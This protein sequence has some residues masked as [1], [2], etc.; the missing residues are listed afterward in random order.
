MTNS[1][2]INQLTV[3]NFG[4]IKDVSVKLTPLHAFI[5]PND[6]GK[7]TLLRAARTGMQL[8]TGKFEGGFPEL[9]Q[10]KE[11]KPFHPGNHQN[12]EI[13]I[14]PNDRLKYSV[15]L[16]AMNIDEKLFDHET[17]T[18]ANDRQIWDK[19]GLTRI[20]FDLLS[21]TDKM[22]KNVLLPSDIP[23]GNSRL[24]DINFEKAIKQIPRMVRLDPDS[25]RQPGGLIPS[26]QPIDF[27]ENGIGLAGVLD[28]L[29]KRKIDG[30]ISLREKV[31]E[32]FPTVAS[33]GLKNITENEMSIEF[34]LKNGA[35]IPASNMSEGM[36][37]YIAFS[38]LQYLEPA[39]ILLVEEPEN[40]LHPSRIKEVMAI[41]RELSTTTQVLIATH[42]PL[43]INE[44]QPEEVSVVWREENTG[45]KVTPLMATQEFDLRSKVYAL[46]ELWLSYADGINEKMLRTGKE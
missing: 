1:M 21:K 13:T 30:Y 15:S 32:L 44:M 5:G 37:Y 29:M 41:I 26:S 24:T 20:F 38:A 19:P 6:S 8:L 36:L 33:L 46:G 45:T 10:D 11:C 35:R 34:E 22:P 28:A 25:L 40:G 16:N 18:H 14:S 43:V 31:I 3:K 12:A 2:L 7:S 9:D 4:C 39:S 42:S 17:R 27:K 23:D